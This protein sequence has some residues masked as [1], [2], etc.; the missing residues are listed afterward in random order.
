MDTIHIRGARTHNLKNI[1]LDLPRDKLIVITGLSGSGKSSLAFDTIYAEGQRRY[2]ESLSSYA[3]QF[4]SMMEK[5][6]VD[7]IEGLSPAISIEQ[8]STSHNPRSTVG[9]VTEI[10]D[11]LRLL[12]ARVGEP[13]CPEHDVV[14]EAQTVSQMVD[15]VLEMPE[16]TKL[17]L[18]APVIDGR[19]GEHL[20]VLAELRAQG[21]IR[22]RIDGQIVELD[23]VPEL[24]KK[25]KHTIEAVVDRF[26][27]RDDLKQRLAESFETALHLS[28]GIA[29]VAYLDQ[30]K[31]Q[32]LVFSAKFACPHCGYSLTELEPRLFSFN[33]PFGACPSCDGLGV[34]Q[35]FDAGRVVH[36][37]ESSL[38]S[39]AIRG[40]DRRNAYYFQLLQSLAKH[41]G[42]DL[43]TPFQDLDEHH[44]QVLLYG[45]GSEKI[46][47]TFF[48]DRGLPRTKK[49]PFEGIIPNME[50]RYR[51]TE[52][53]VV[54]DELA[55]YLSHQPCPDCGGARLRTEARNVF[56]AGHNLPDITAMAVGR[57]HTFFGDLSLPGKRGQIA[58][59]IVKEVQERLKFLVNVGLDYLSL[60][61]SADTLSGGEAQRI[62]LASQIGAGLVG[63]MYVLDE[64]S[65]GL[66]QRDNE[67][68]LSTLTYLR[69]LGNTVIVVEHDEEA[70]RS[71]DYVIDIGPGAGVHGGEIVAQGTAEQVMNNPASETGQYLSGKKEI[72]IPAARTPVDPERMLSIR[73][74]SGNNLKGINV[75]I[76]V[77]L[78]TC[79]T[80]V[81]GSGKSTLINDTLYR[82]AAIIIN[83][84]GE[85]PAP[86][87]EMLGLEQFDKVVDIDQSPIGR[88]PRSNPATYT[89]LF[90]PIRDLFA[91]TQEARSRGYG[92][93]R[94]SFNVKGGRCE[95]CQG[96]GVIKVEMHFLPDI[97][98]PCDVCKGQ[99]YNRETLDVKYKGKNIY[100][101]L[102]MTVEE[103]L[104]FFSA[105]PAIQRKLQTLM[106]VGLSYIT[107]GQNATTLSGGEAQRVKLARELSKRD[108]GKTI[109]IL[110]EPTTGLHFHDIE[111]LLSVLS[112]LRDHGNTIVIIEHNLDVIKTAD[113]II[114]VGPEGGDKGGEIV[115][116]G[117]PEDV[118]Q[119]T[120]SHTGRFLKPML[121]PPAKRKK[122]S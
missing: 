6:D 114:D 98:V 116:C 61:R 56:I 103:A 97:Y 34:K 50:R 22:A 19:K 38:A 82:N 53:N 76:P 54:R 99:R 28:D 83:K 81:S 96:D 62:R 107:L 118:A 59:K 51:E 27:V 112:R 3:R 5:P 15:H 64:P 110:D 7:H 94:F 84:A 57:A 32:D 36:H 24:D 45:S 26:K 105:V 8:K 66:H 46:E 73:G 122:A 63:V 113:W 88:T 69:D 100:E 91:G 102:E 68:L 33:N 11:Y 20:Q 67:R 2:V 49:A 74:A 111:Q 72:A 39:G 41:Y 70:I 42:F 47:M 30:D 29:R 18:L 58:A 52:S 120:S 71:A 44:R 86:C 89:G 37:P 13:R 16:G 115:I 14:L 87:A 60:E 80:G 85:D 79:V 12:F 31:K 101:V 4:L 78:M 119:H 35:F 106:D 77:G 92:P 95:A 10:Y 121:K 48:S 117:T 40:W 108:T 25:R 43:D 23:Q 21:F 75:D 104:Q 1:D 109:Y 93:G 65:I 9:T 90:T 17:M 55:K